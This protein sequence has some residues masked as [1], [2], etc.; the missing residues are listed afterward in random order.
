MINNGLICMQWM[1]ENCRSLLLKLEDWEILSWL[2]GAF[3]VVHVDMR[4]YF[5]KWI[6]E[7]DSNSNWSII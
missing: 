6:V 1:N 4:T 7:I 3:M 5:N 2:N